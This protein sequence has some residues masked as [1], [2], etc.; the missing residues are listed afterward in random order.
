LATLNTKKG[1]SPILE[2]PNEVAFS[3]AFDRF[4]GAPRA[5]CIQVGVGPFAFLLNLIHI[6]FGIGR[7]AVMNAAGVLSSSCLG[8]SA[9]LPLE[10]TDD[11]HHFDDN[12]ATGELWEGNVFNDKGRRK[13][14][15]HNNPN[16]TKVYSRLAKLQQCH[17][18]I[19]VVTDGS[20]SPPMFYQ[21]KLRCELGS[22]KANKGQSEVKT[23][24]HNPLYEPL[25]KVIG[26]SQNIDGFFY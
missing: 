6:S 2:I 9:S 11:E 1:L 24:E 26:V 10:L 3:L 5:R 4:P 25:P 16:A 13:K 7:A 12:L 15:A 8:S 14:I 18:K 20:G 23:R 19:S 17:G 22:W 21:Q